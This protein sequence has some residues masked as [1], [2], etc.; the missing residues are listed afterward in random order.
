MEEKDIDVQEMEKEELS[1]VAAG[2]LQQPH[3]RA[4][5]QI[6]TCFGG[7]YKCTTKGCKYEGKAQ[8]VQNLVWK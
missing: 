8:P 4:C 3:C 1:A 2:L 7:T 5:G 6:V